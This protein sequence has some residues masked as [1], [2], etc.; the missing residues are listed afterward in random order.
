MNLSRCIFTIFFCLVS[1]SAHSKCTGRF[2]NPI[3]D[4]CWSCLFPITIGGFRVSPEG[5]DTDNTKNIVC[6]CG[7]PIPRVGIPISFWEPAKMIDVT[8]T[9]YCFVNLGGFKL[10]NRGIKGHGDVANGRQSRMRESFYHTHVYDYFPLFWLEIIVDFLC[11]DKGGINIPYIS[12]IDPYWNDDEDAFI[13]NAEA[14]LFANPIAQ[15]ACAADC[16]KATNGFPFDFMFWCGG[17]QGSMYPFVGSVSYHVGGVQASLLITQRTIARLHRLSALPGTAGD[18]ALCG[19]YYA[20]IIPKT[21][22]KTQML[23]PVPSTQSKQCY[24]LGRSEVLWASGK[25]FP[26]E[27]ED[28]GYLI[29]RKRTCCLL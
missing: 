26:Y 10:M 2:V 21:Q 5:E 16:A 25:E 3:T 27:G 7:R 20:P 13:F 6:M 9:P 15:S 17:C 24:P 28:F 4:I 22:Y 11:M 1:L 8:R 18:K 19:H 23:Y 12:E 29:W 14:V